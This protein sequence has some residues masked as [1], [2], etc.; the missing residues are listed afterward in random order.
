[1][2]STDPINP[3]ENIENIQVRFDSLKRMGDPKIRM[4]AAMGSLIKSKGSD[5]LGK[6]QRLSAPSKIIKKK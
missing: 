2:V 6:I 4:R 3:I 1:M 5:K